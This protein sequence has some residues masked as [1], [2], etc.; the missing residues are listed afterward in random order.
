MDITTILRS[1]RGRVVLPES[2]KFPGNSRK[3]SRTRKKSRDRP[4][5]VQKPW[6]N[7]AFRFQRRPG[8]PSKEVQTVPNGSQQLHA[9]A[10]LRADGGFRRLAPRSV[11]GNSTSA[12]PPTA[13]VS[14]MRLCALAGM[15]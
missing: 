14:P 10:V 5:P 11:E 9:V 12:I 4:L 3:R 2:S 13:P 7:T 1:D 15:G 6:E 8:M